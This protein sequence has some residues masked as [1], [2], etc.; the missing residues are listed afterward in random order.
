V[1][2]VFVIFRQRPHLVERTIPEH[3]RRVYKAVD[4]KRD[5][6]AIARSAGLSQFDAART[7]YELAK[8]RFVESNPPNK[9]KVCEL[10]KLCVE[11]I[12]M[13]MV[14][15]ERSRLALEFEHELN[16]FAAEYGLIV[17]M[18]SG[19]TNR[20][21]LE[22]HYSPIELIDLYKMFIG[23]QNNKLSKVFEPRLFQGLMEGLYLNAEPEIRSMMRMYEFFDIDNIAILD[24]FDSNQPTPA[25]TAELLSPA[26]PRIA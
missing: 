22:S 14:L 24:M 25:P 10:F 18:A 4:G 2:S 7:L 15:Y 21:D 5:V 9:V 8:D 13:K 16:R 23:I 19:R 12:Y 6:T 11:S 17:R 1:P 26:P 20:G 3:L